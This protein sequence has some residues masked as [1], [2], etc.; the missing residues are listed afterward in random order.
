MASDPVIAKTKVHIRQAVE[1]D[2]QIVCDLLADLVRTLRDAPP[3]GSTLETIR[4]HGFGDKRQFEALIAEA[5]GT[6]AGLVLYFYTYSTWRG[7][8]GVYV[9]D[10]HVVERFRGHGL[11]RRLLADAA[12]RGRADGCTHLRLSVDPGNEAALTFYEAVGLEPRRDETICQAAGEA[13]RHL[14]E[15][16]R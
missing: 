16:G 7:C 4:H 12:R 13:F 11:G 14:A 8:L 3:C 6:P 15:D 10:L 2:A 5:E 9:Q 1:K